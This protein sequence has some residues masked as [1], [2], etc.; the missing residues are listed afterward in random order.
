[1]F[2]EKYAILGA[3]TYKIAD[4]GTAKKY[5]DD[6]CEDSEKKLTSILGSFLS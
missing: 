4:M 6:T 2:F 5:T 3:A 1:M